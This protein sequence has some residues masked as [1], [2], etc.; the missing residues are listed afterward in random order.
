MEDID[1]PREQPGAREAIYLALDRHGLYSDAAILEQSQQ[2]K[3][4]AD[5]ITSLAA[6]VYPC[7]CSRHRIRELTSVY[8]GYCRRQPPAPGEKTA[9]RLSV[10]QLTPE[11]LVCALP[12][13]PPG[14]PKLDL[15]QQCTHSWH[16]E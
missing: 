3:D 5:A 8:D 4:Y 2:L 1:P 7:R 6:A 9:L 15:P 12:T 10:D 14:S 13:A 11:Q 16:G